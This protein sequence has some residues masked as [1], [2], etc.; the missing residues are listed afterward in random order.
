MSAE[1]PAARRRV[2]RDSPVMVESHLAYRNLGNLAF[3]NVSADWGL[4]QK[5]VSFGSAFGDLDGDG[6]LDLVYSNYQKGITLLRNDCD[7]G[8]RVT[9]DLR[10]TVSNRFGVGATIR[11]ESALGVQVRQLVW[12]AE[13]SRA[14]SRSCTSGWETTRSSAVWLQ[15]GPAG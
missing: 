4:N 14:A 5:G 12:R 15:R 3:E 2:M 1:T 8:H 7:T 13:F 11:I 9:V 6:N 10:G